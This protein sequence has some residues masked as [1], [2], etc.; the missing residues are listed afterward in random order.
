MPT[1]RA[2]LAAGVVDGKLYVAGGE[3]PP[4]RFDTLEVYDPATDTWIPKASMPTAR[5]NLVGGVVGGRLYA[6]GG[7]SGTR[8]AP[9]RLDTVEVYDPAT[10]TWAAAA[11][12]STARSELAAEV[13]DGKLYALGGF[14]D[15]GA[16][17]V[18]AYNPPPSP[19]PPSPPPLSPPPPGP[20]PSSP[21]PP[22]S[23]PKTEVV[24]GAAA[25]GAAL[26]A[27]LAAAIVIK[28]R[29]ALYRKQ[30]ARLTMARAS[31]SPSLAS[32]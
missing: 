10:D 26:L 7:E 2:R 27:F 5:S 30:T 20:P 28:S 23:A 31:A 11:P 16:A 6:V 21:P 18:E 1:L 4:N 17:T 12:M 19:P 32:V 22:P 8:S 9:E 13:V 29:R 3:S 14:N 15:K 25:G 24:I